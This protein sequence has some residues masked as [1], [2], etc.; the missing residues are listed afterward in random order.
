MKTIIIVFLRMSTLFV[1]KSP[2]F[3]LNHY[4]QSIF[5]FRFIF[6]NAKWE[7]LAD[8]AILCCAFPN[9]KCVLSFPC[10]QIDAAVTQC[11]R[12]VGKGQNNALV[13]PEG[14]ESNYR[15]LCDPGG[16]GKANDGNM[17]AKRKEQRTKEKKIFKTLLTVSIYPHVQ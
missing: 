14:E 12:E 17:E 9:L 5:W 7:N 6:L 16:R 3:D 8:T 2:N 4:Y 10:I 15:H 1:I 11:G 13:G